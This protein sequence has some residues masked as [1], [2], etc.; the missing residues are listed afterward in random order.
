MK[1]FTF[2]QKGGGI[3][4]G[5]GTATIGVS[6][7]TFGSTL[8]L[9]ID[10][11]THLATAMDL[12]GTALTLDKLDVKLKGSALTWLLDKLEGLLQGVLKTT[13]EKQVVTLVDDLVATNGTQASERERARAPRE[14]RARA[15]PA[16]HRHAR[17]PPPPP[18]AD[19]PPLPPPC[20]ALQL[21]DGWVTPYLAPPT[22]TA[23]RRCLPSPSVAEGGAGRCARLSR[24]RGDRI[25]RALRA[26][27]AGRAAHR[28]HG[29]GG[30]RRLVLAPVVVPIPGLANLSFSLR[31]LNATGLTSLTAPALFGRNKSKG[32]AHTLTFEAGLDRS[33]SRRSSTSRSRRWRVAVS[34][35]TLV[36]TPTST[37]S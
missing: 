14:R 35:G 31:S 26:Q 21:L 3:L 17:A 29:G 7:A 4:K 10:K 34:A 27:R 37:R 20:Q 11:R 15:R 13:L 12:K 25:R 8:E 19:P 6:G 32:E 22:S 5:D 36:E 16:A 28:R 30:L 2:E 33:T 24:R 1:H 9:T 23:G 18:G